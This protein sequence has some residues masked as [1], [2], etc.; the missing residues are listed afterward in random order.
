M[1]GNFVLNE[2]DFHRMVE[3]VLEASC[4]LKQSRRQ[5]YYICI[6][7]CIICII[8]SIIY[9]CKLTSLMRIYK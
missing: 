2:Q 6:I 4:N 3:S 1:N 8:Q 5:T 9:S 7:Y